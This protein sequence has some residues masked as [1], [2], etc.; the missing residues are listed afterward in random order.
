MSD[1][2]Q[3]GDG[4][5]HLAYLLHMATRRMR[6]EAEE[7]VPERLTALRAA[8][9]R[10][11]DAIPSGGA[12]AS[13]LAATLR[14]SK[15]GL[16]QLVAQLANH[17]YVEVRPDPVDRR[18]RLVCCTES[19][20]SAQQTMRSRLAEVEER[21]RQEAGSDRYAVFREVISEL[22]ASYADPSGRT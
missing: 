15:Q 19:G 21:W 17:G 8:Q 16:G 2:N 11:L 14:V 5:Q 20:R 12:R 3:H 22:V 1:V 9:A 18:A 7:G 4:S 6:S 10:L 13:E